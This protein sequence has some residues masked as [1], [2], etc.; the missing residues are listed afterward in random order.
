M[1]I[2]SFY[3]V[4]YVCSRGCGHVCTSLV[5]SCQNKCSEAELELCWLSQHTHLSHRE[6]AALSTIR[7][8]PLNYISQ[9]SYSVQ[10]LHVTCHVRGWQKCINKRIY[11]R[12]DV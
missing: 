1:H 12:L 6:E 2:G 11:L 10:T 9:H 3:K 5:I 8:T 4:R 7:T